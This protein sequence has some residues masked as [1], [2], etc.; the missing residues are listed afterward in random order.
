M[1]EKWKYMSWRAAGRVE[2]TERREK[3]EDDTINYLTLV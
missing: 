1:E 3:N 2:L